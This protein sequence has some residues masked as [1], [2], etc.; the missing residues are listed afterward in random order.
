MNSLDSVADES[1]VVPVSKINPH[2]TK[3]SQRKL[4]VLILQRQF[5]E[6]VMK[7]SMNNPKFSSYSTSFAMLQSHNAWLNIQVEYFRVI[8]CSLRPQAANCSELQLMKLCLDAEGQ[9]LCSAAERIVPSNTL[10]FYNIFGS[11]W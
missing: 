1:S 11:S 2:A 9:G 4:P 6:T 5:L 10:P 7:L 8:P 3:S